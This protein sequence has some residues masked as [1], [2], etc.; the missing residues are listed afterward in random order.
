MAPMESA[1]KYGEPSKMARAYGHSYISDSVCI[2]LDR[3][4]RLFRQEFASA[5]LLGL[6]TS[7]DSAS[8]GDHILL[9]RHLLDSVCMAPK[10]P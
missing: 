2:L 1:A 8:L 7:S 5:L 10:Q 6:N 3:D 4:E 9:S